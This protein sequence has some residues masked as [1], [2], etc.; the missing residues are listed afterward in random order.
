MA[1]HIPESFI[2][3][4]LSR[5]DIVE[6]INEIAPLKRAGANY[7]SR[8]PFHVE[9]TPSFTVS[10]S[11]QF[12]HC[13]GCGAHGNALRFLMEYSGF[14][15]L[16]AI[17]ALA[18]R[19]GLKV[20]KEAA[21]IKRETKFE[22]VYEVLAKASQYFQEQLQRHP[23]KLRA[24]DYLKG[25]GITGKT[26]RS[27]CIGFAPGGW[28][29]MMQAFPNEI[30]DLLSAGLL[31]A[32]ER[33]VSNGIRKEETRSKKEESKD[34]DHYYDRFRDRIMFPIRDRRG[35]VVGFGGRVID[36]GEPKYLNSPETVVFNKS[37]Q[38]YGL[39]EARA[40]NR[41]LE[42]LIIVEGYLD[43]V[44]LAQFGFSNV[45][46]TLGTA[47]TE[48]HLEL[49]FK[50]V[51]E[52]YF[53]FDGDEAGRAAQKRALNLCVPHIQEGRMIKFVMLPLGD[54]PD[55][56]VRKHGKAGFLN[57][58]QEA[59]SLS[60][61]LFESLSS[62]LDLNSIEGRSELVRTAR[63]LIQKLP[64]GVFQELMIGRL[65]QFAGMMPGT[66]QSRSGLYPKKSPNLYAQKSQKNAT[67][68]K[69][70]PPSAA[71]KAIALLLNHR[72]LIKTT[73][74]LG[75]LTGVDTHGTPLLCAMIE[76]LRKDPNLAIESLEQQIDSKVLGEL[77]LTDI[78]PFAD[79][80]P[81]EGIEAEWLGALNRLEGRA[82]EQQLEGLLQRAKEG[83]LTDQEKM[84][85]KQFLQELERD[86]DKE[87]ERTG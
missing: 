33:A 31:I 44:A 87:K 5:V 28:E 76:I 27:F 16:D 56:F 50:Q 54:D 4:L 52:L 19:V 23:T 63:A 35:R 78:I 59:K 42:S 64:K 37:Q 77:R 51:N 48:K 2:E 81:L 83:A 85:L 26:A 13:F 34:R 58:L 22:K 38:V 18:S 46:A 80:V 6:I 55:S 49:L 70:L 40:A 67:P 45:V 72:E 82:K 53:C 39:Y 47:L 29:G 71:L 74:K 9:K 21:D 1:G 43:V 24:I 66:L 69:A 84:R 61:F 68:K 25:R 8:C 57:K 75:D 60:D 14:H 79:S 12:Y 3:E 15:F 17:E 7:V 10:Q 11:K 36:K 73:E 86:K 20:P 41:T 32:N 30:P 62:H 65:E